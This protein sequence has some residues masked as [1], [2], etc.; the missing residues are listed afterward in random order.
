M[1]KKGVVYSLMKLVATKTDQRTNLEEVVNVTMIPKENNKA[2][3]IIILNGGGE[4][5]YDIGDIR[6]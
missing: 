3:K 1:T 5:K 6:K 4:K 2:D